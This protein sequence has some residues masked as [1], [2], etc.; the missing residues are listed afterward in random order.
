MYLEEKPMLPLND[1]EKVLYANE[2]HCYICGKEFSND[3]NSAYCKKAVKL[4]IT[5]ILLVTFKA[6]LIVYAI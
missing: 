2:K 5:V 3:K 1:N 4:G 6:L